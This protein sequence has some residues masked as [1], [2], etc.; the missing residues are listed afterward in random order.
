MVVNCG[1]AITIDTLSERGEFLGGLVLPGV[2]LMQRS[3]VGATSQLVLEHGN[4]AKFPLN[5][6]DAMLSGAIQA[7]CGAIER[8]YLL[9]EDDKVPVFLSGGGAGILRESI[10]LPFNVVDNLVLQGLSRISEEAGA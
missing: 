4:Y 6:A 7:C 1:T 3:L 9:L 2:E 10:N 5:T 8:Q